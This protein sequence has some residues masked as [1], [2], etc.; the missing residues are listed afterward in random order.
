[1]KRRAKELKRNQ[2]FMNAS[3]AELGKLKKDKDRVHFV[4]FVVGLRVN[5]DATAKSNLSNGVHEC[6][7]L[8]G[9]SGLTSWAVPEATSAAQFRD[10]ITRALPVVLAPSE[11]AAAALGAVARGVAMVLGVVKGK[12]AK[13]YDFELLADALLTTLDAVRGLGA[14]ADPSIEPL[15]KKDAARL[16]PFPTHFKSSFESAVAKKTMTTHSPAPVG[17]KGD[18]A[19]SWKTATKAR[20]SAPALVPAHEILTY[21]SPAKPGLATPADTKGTSR[22][23]APTRPR[24]GGEIRLSA[25][26]AVVATG[27]AIAAG[28]GITTTNASTIAAATTAASV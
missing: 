6:L 14:L 17:G 9:D 21:S 16:V 20:R 15:W 18:A 5:L 4:D 7:R 13:S 2:E 27:R 25:I 26:S 24:T 28:A 1:M 12:R 8:L 11:A 10:D 22:S 23:S 3:L 19:S